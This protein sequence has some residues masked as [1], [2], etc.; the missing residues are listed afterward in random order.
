M[1]EGRVQ[2]I[3]TTALDVL[4]ILLFAAGAAMLVWPWT[5][6]GALLAAGTVVTAASVLATRSPRAPRARGDR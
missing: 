2:M 4:G 3:V 5:P 1:T 6:G